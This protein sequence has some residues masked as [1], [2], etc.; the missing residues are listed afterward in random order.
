MKLK[1][2]IFV[3]LLFVSLE[4][5]AL[6]FEMYSENMILYNLN[7]KVVI[8]EKNSNERTSIASLTKIMTLIV[9]IEQ[10]DDIKEKVTLDTVIFEGLKEANAS[11]AGFKVGQVVTYEDLLY[12]VFL[13][14]GADA[15]NALAYNLTDGIDNYVE[16]MNKKALELNLKNTHFVNTS[17]L[18]IEN[19]Y[20]TV[21]DVS[22]ILLYSLENKTFK[23]IF[24]TKQ[25]LTSDKSL[26]FYST[27]QKL[28]NV[29]NIDADFL[30]GG[31][32]GYTYDAGLCLASVAYDS[33]NDINYMLVTTKAPITT[34][35]LAVK[36]AK[37]IYEH[38][39]DNYKYYNLSEN[40]DLT[41]KTTSVKEKEITIKLPE[42]NV[43][44]KNDFDMDKLQTNYTGKK[45][46]SF[47]DKINTKIGEV[48]YIYDGKM[49]DKKYV[50]LNQKL[51]FSLP[52]FLLN[53]IV[54]IGLLFLFIIMLAIKK[55]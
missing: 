55:Q 8:N 22:K 46:L 1:S 11:V 25:Y 34:K 51:T 47:D 44:M 21:S 24:E 54:I 23:K 29:Y 45:V 14:S 28:L 40:K 52:D 6:E 41:F 36:D 30:I 39:F 50:L 35:E 38:Y 3:L 15:T 9:A 13:P 26:T 37:T 16:L 10:I 27:M 32:T 2:I 43:Y 42:Y 17:G 49:L 33:K 31:K 18:D 12:G 4:V 5:N 19:H 7:D 20:S 48:E 53:N